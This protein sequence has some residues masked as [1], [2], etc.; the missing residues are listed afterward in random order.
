MG[1]MLS[2]TMKRTL[3]GVIVSFGASVVSCDHAGGGLDNEAMR[4]GK[5]YFEERVFLQCGDSWF[6]KSFALGTPYEFVQ[7]K[8]LDYGLEKFPVNEVDNANGIEWKGQL[9]TKGKMFRVNMINQLTFKP[10]RWSEWQAWGP[11][12]NPALLMVNIYRAK[13]QWHVGDDSR[14]AKIDFSCSEVSG[15]T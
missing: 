3:L 9:W 13:G 14:P 2:I 12:V 6:R 1:N 11:F 8:N 15:G 10:T 5:K 7:V 4:L